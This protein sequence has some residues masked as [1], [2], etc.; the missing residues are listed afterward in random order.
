MLKPNENFKYYFASGQSIVLEGHFL[1]RKIPRLQSFINEKRPILRRYRDGGVTFIDSGAFSAMTRGIEIDVDDYIEFLNE[2]DTGVE[3]C[4]Q[5]DVIPFEMTIKKKI[6]K[7][8]DTQE[9]V[10]QE[11]PVEENTEQ[12]NEEQQEEVEEEEQFEIIHLKVDPEE[13]A[14]KTWDN[15]WYMRS[16]LKSP[17]KLLY[18]FH[19]GE[20]YI[21]LEKALKCDEITYIA[22][23]GVA[24]KPFKVRDKFFETC[25]EII[26]KV[27]PTVKTHAFGMTNR[28][29]LEKYP[30]TSADSTSWMYPAKFGTIQWG[31]WQIVNISDRKKQDE[32][33]VYNLPNRQEITDYVTNLGHN[34]DEIVEISD[35]RRYYQIDY[36]LMKYDNFASG[37]NYVETDNY[38]L[39]LEW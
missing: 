35:K 2:Y 21:W 14:Q 7:E 26:S 38:Q 22:L 34:I 4:C 28:K 36:W 15:Y 33:H 9:K 31:D 16:K 13:S 25:F 18:V 6:E 20:D 37:I 39:Q 1:D 17:E 32:D 12:P 27:K 29:L 10:Q 19:E 3:I 11:T 24:K 30:F 23:G 5:W 8:E